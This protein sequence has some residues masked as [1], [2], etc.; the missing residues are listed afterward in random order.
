MKKL[1]VILL[2]L[3]FIGFG[4]IDTINYIKFK[5]DIN[6]RKNKL[7]SKWENDFSVSQ[8]QIVNNT[9]KSISEYDS[10]LNELYQI[11]KKTY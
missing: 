7:I 3:P 9:Y 4:Q 2:C 11:L 1:L 5:G 10:F 8:V 6:E